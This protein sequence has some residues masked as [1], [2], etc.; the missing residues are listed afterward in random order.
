MYRFQAISTYLDTLPTNPEASLI[1]IDP[2]HPPFASSH[3]TLR[4]LHSLAL[5]TLSKEYP[6]CST[7]RSQPC[8]V[9]DLDVGA[10][11]SH[12]TFRVDVETR[13]EEEQDGGLRPYSAE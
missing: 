7:T 13:V 4:S 10:R 11:P 6:R 2:A 8:S 9:H 12:A 5:S 3:S 1:D